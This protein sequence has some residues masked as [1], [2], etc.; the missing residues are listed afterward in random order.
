MKKTMVDYRRL[1]WNNLNTPEFSHL[2]LLLG[3]PVY[4]LL[5]I[6]TE[7]LIPVD[8]CH[9]IHAPLD[10]LIPFR[11][12][13]AL[14]YV[15][16]Y[17]LIVAS[18]LYFLLYRADSFKNLQTYIFLTQ[19]MATII[20]VLYPSRQ[21]LRP[22]VFPRENIWTGILGAI[23]R[24][25]TNTCVF[26]SLHAAISIAI[27]SVWCRQKGIS[28]WIKG[29]IVWFCAMVCLSVCFVK[30]HSVLDVLAAIPVCLVAEWFVFFKKRK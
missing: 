6:L 5:Y 10:D 23:Y 20:F 25:D 26:P 14:F 19:M 30:Q 22:E 18:L 13:F 7:N 8:A 1:R 21:M 9:V 17:V 27:A 4:F 15:G 12:G 2:K 3:W 24:I 29:G 28:L 16:W 11:E